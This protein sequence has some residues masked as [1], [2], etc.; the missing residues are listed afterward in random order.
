[1]RK[2]G[3]IG[4]YD[5]T[6]MILNIAKILTVMNQKV[7]VID[8]TTNEKVKYVVPAINPTVSYITTFEDIDIAIGF[9]TIED[10]KRYI[11]SIE[12]LN[13]D[14]I[15]IDADK[16]EIINNFGLEQAQKNYFVTSFD[17]FYLKKSIEI[18]SQL[19][20]TIN[21]TKILFSKD[22]L[23]EDDDYLNY[24][25]L[26][27]KI[28]WDDMRIYFPL[29]NGDLSVLNENQR[30]Q[31]IKLKKLSTQY[32]EGLIFIVQQILEQKSDSNARKAVKMLEKGV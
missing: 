28:I 2:I 4:N 26:G 11:G 13:Y 27:S 30:I 25:S 1:M 7:L 9:N 24:L 12:K 5:K 16:I 8:S 18:L 6:D 23:K 32:K 19:E 20:K 31:R 29:E 14:V 10:I 22:M 15:L 17:I 21:L 3:F